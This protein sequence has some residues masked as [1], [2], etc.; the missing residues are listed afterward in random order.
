MTQQETWVFE[1]AGVKQQASEQCQECTADPS[2]VYLGSTHGIEVFCLVHLQLQ[3]V[4]RALWKLVR[5]SP[6]QASIDRSNWV[7]ALH[8]LSPS[9]FL[10]RLHCLDDLVHHTWV[11]QSCCIPEAVLLSAQDLSQNSS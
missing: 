3:G 6:A 2:R 1:S 11:A 5:C 10:A 4:F 7:S 9:L 8:S